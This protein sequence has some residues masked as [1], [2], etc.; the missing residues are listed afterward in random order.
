M[1][2]PKPTLPSPS[3][4]VA[5]IALVMATTGTAA[6]VTVSFARNS[7]RVDGI[8]A[9]S[10][11]ASLKRT[12]GKLIATD[13]TGQIQ[14]KY[15]N[16]ISGHGN[17]QVFGA[18]IDVVDNATGGA[19]PLVTI[20]FFGTLA[21]S[22]KDEN[23]K[24]G[25]EDPQSTVTFTNASGSTLALARTGAGV[26]TSIKDVQNGTIDSFTLS[27]AHTY[28]YNVQSPGGTNLVIHGV[29]NQLGRGTAAA[30]CNEYGQ[31]LRVG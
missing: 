2:K 31:A 11:G 12:A 8:H 6:A 1:K 25:V 14:S 22:C 26:T 30:K 15:L 3:M 24:V 4:V 16:A 17:A 29:V 21:V 5:L 9:V 18:N 27:N 20:P 10:A 7:D 23:N 13:K 19:A 28:E